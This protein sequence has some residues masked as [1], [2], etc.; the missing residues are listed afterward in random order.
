MIDDVDLFYTDEGGREKTEVIILCADSFSGCHMF[1]GRNVEER[2]SG[3][4]PIMEA[5]GRT[6]R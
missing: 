1:G 2:E 5:E 6:L 3:V 4:G